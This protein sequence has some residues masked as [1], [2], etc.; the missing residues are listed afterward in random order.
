MRIY[1]DNFNKDIGDQKLILNEINNFKQIANENKK[2]IVNFQEDF[3][4]KLND[5]NQSNNN[6]HLQFENTK[7][8]MEVRFNLI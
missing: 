1:I 7:S 2:N 3:E 4:K 6:Y 5:I 8:L